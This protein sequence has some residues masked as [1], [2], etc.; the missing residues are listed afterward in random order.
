[1]K[2]KLKEMQLTT[3]EE[4]R[5]RQTLIKTYKLIYKLV[6]KNKLPTSEKRKES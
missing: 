1:M 6:T 2:R 3:H 5:K 4:R